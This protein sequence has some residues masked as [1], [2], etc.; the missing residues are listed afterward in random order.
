MK[1]LEEGKDDKA[2]GVAFAAPA[3]VGRG[4]FQPGLPPALL[5][6]VFQAG[7]DKLPVF[8]GGQNEQ[9]GYT[10][11]KLMAVFTPSDSDKARL[12]QA[13][14]RLSEQIGREMLS[15]YLASLRAKADVKLNQANLEKR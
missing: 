5:T 9:G 12:D 15:A 11:V 10:I 1:L 8:T 6:R 14:A 3:K 2:A 13:S 7:G 4:Q